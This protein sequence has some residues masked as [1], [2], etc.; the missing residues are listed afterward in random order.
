MMEKSTFR[1]FVL[2]LGG[3]ALAFALFLVAQPVLAGQVQPDELELDNRISAVS[4]APASTAAGATTT[5]T[6]TF[7][8]TEDLTPGGF[9]NFNFEGSGNCQGDW[10]NCQPSF[11][12]A[13]LVSG[14][15]GGEFEKF[16]QGF[17]IRKEP[18]TAGTYTLVVGGVQNPVQ[19]MSHYR[20]YAETRAWG[21][22]PPEEG[23]EP[24]RTPSDPYFFAPVAVKG[25]ITDPDDEAAGN[26][27]VGFHTPDFTFN[28]QSNADRLGFYS[29][30]AAGFPNGTIIMEIWL[31]PDYGDYI[32][33]DPF[34][35]VYSGTTVTVNQQLRVATKTVVGTLKYNTGATVTTGAEV[36]ANRQGGGGGKNAQV[37]DDGTYELVLSGGS[38]EI[39]PNC[40]WDNE[41]Q[42][43]RVCDWSYNG[44]GQMVEFANNDTPETKTVNL[45]VTQTNATVK[46]RV[47][48]PN[49][50]WLTGGWVELRKGDGQGMGNGLDQNGRFSIPTTDGSFELGIHPD[51]QNPNLAKYYFPA[52]KVTVSAGQTLDLGVLTMQQKTSKITGT[53]TLDTGDPVE[54]VR[55]NCWSRQGGGGWG[56]APTDSDG[57]YAI[58]LGVGQYE[59]RPDDRNTNYIYPQMGPPDVHDLQ[60]NETISGV[61]FEVQQADAQLN[62]RLV[63]D[64]GNAVTNVWGWAYA[65]KKDGGW[66]PGNEFGSGIDRGIATIP[67]MGG[68][69]YTVGV[70]MPPEGIQYLL[71]EEEEVALDEGETADVLLVIEPPDAQIRGYLKDQNGKAIKGVEAEVFAM[72]GET[73]GPGGVWI[74]TRV[75]QADGSYTLGVKGG[76]KYIM[77]YHFMMGKGGTGSDFLNAPPNMAPFTVPVNGTVTKILTAFRATAHLNV[78][79]LDPD[80]GK[81]KWGHAWCSNR[82]YMEDKVQLD[83]LAPVI[84]TGNEIKNGA[85]RINLIAGQFEC[86]AGFG[87][88]MENNWMPPDMQEVTLAD[89]D[90]KSITLQFG[91]ADSTLVGTAVYENGE[92]V[93]WGFCHAFTFNGKFSG[94]EILN[95]S[96]EIPINSGET[97]QMGCDSDN[98]RK[99]SRSEEIAVSVSQAGEIDIG[100]ITLLQKDWDIPE[101]IT[102]QF[103]AGTQL[104]LTLPDGTTISASPGAFGSEGTTVNLMASP[105]IQLFFDHNNKPLNFAWNLEATVSSGTLIESFNSNV[106]VCIPYSQGVIDEEGYNEDEIVAKYYKST[107]GTWEL[108]DGVTQDTDANKVC[109]QTDHFTNFALVAGA[110]LLEGLGV[111]Q[112][113]ILVTPLSAGGPQVIIADENGN[114]VTNFF[115]YSSTLRIGIQAVTADVDGDGE[116]EIVVAPGAG[117]GPQIRIFNKA[118]QVEGQFWAYDSGL[119]MGVNLSVVDDD[120]DGVYDIVAVPMAGGG[121]QIKVFS[122]AGSLKHQFFA[123][124]E[125]FRG[126][127]ELAVGDVNGDG[128]QELVV[129]PQS[130][131]GPQIRV[132]KTD[133][134]V[135]SQ[136]FAYASTVRGGYNVTLG[137]VNGSGTYDII[138]SPKAGLGPQVA[139]FDWEGTLLG[140][141]FAF[142]ETFRGG[143]Y[144]SAG[145]VDGDGNLELVATPESNAGP[146]VR[147]FEV[148]GTVLS[149]FW[150]YSSALRGS[151]TSFVADL[152]GD[153]TTEIATAPGTGMG[154]QVRTFNQNGGALSQFFSHHTGFRGGITISPSI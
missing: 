84:D 3:A 99:L 53:V 94:G 26:L 154:P 74:G 17:S 122:H 83:N 12:N 85:G 16:D 118:G 106:S 39:R 72:A 104:S 91:E 153:G 127:V 120:G 142:A 140:R 28:A 89:G 60:A 90:T 115:A 103:D 98:M 25:T 100:E 40:G 71:R 145:D 102:A 92:K 130:A 15:P 35:F 150:A 58:W 46:G 18:V 101:G 80:G 81:V 19:L 149:Q 79:L 36:N 70:H 109:Y 65:R 144:A 151:F 42:Q 121:P 30:P 133:G 148:D 125:T 59:C 68:T 143:I 54:G 131:A 57:K 76:Q 111:T 137:D 64:D 38:W 50:N 44:P 33:P 56:Q 61:D 14:F 82:R 110:N 51:N 88:E 139:V 24:A 5:Y 136:F 73:M 113:D 7:T 78:T 107:T 13:A 69:T 128:E 48:L 63:D 43:Q 134:S 8:L 31:N 62:V 123:Y 45:T 146:Q 27:G 86:G 21:E 117:A 20:V 119:R 49:G 124:A 2:G 1:S 152:N 138:I 135:V 41:N 75:N 147:V 34:Q 22:E 87:K 37:G 6:V 108:P 77:G 114:V 132:L 10:Q 23:Q 67:L 47:K 96:F 112:N 9:I 93:Q 97:W 4:F 141:F 129:A 32:A 105:N 95:G 116:I 11:Q 29:V 66:G 52:I 126:G 55:I